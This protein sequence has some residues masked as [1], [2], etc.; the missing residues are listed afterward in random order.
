MFLLFQSPAAASPWDYTIGEEDTPTTVNTAATSA[1]VDTTG[2]EIRLP[3]SA[4]NTVAFW[5]DGSAAF[6]VLTP[7]E[8]KHYSYT[9]TQWVENS[10]L[11]VGPVSNPA[12]VAAP[13]PF[14]DV[15]VA[16]GDSLRHYS[17]TGSEMLN[18]P[19]LAVA[20]LAGVAALGAR[21]LDTAGLVGDQVHVYTGQNRNPALEPSVSFAN[22]VDLAL[23]QDSN[24]M[25]VLEP[26]RVRY[27]LSTGSSMVEAPALAIT[28][29]TAP[30]AVA[31]GDGFDVAVI[32]GNQVKHYSF[33]G[34][35][36]VYSSYLS[37]TS[38]L[39][40]P[41]S[42]ALRPGSY[43]RLVADGDQVKYY[44]WNG[45]S[46]DVPVTIPVPGLSS[47]G[48][49]APAAAVESVGFDPG[50]PVSKVRVRAAHDLPDGTMVTWSVTADGAD[51]VKRWRVR[52]TASGSVL[53]VSSDNG[54]TW[55]SIGTADG[56]APGADNAQ[57]WA[58]V[59]AGR[60][61]R[62]RAELS[63]TGSDT[64]RIR[65]SVPGG[66][67]VR[68]DV[69]RP[70]DPPKV[71]PG[72]PACHATTT[73]T[74]SWTFSD[75]DPGDRQ[76]AYRVQIVKPDLELVLDTGK[77]LSD[78]TSYTVPTSTAPDQAGPLWSAGEYEFKVRVKVWDS[79]DL[80][81]EWSDYADFCVTAFE[82]PR[83][84][85]IVSPPP[86]QASPDPDDPKTHIVI[87]PGMT[88]ADLPKVKAGA[89]VTVIIDSVGPLT[90][91]NPV[92]S[93]G[94]LQATTTGVSN[95]NSWGSKV[96]RF[97]VDFWTSASLEDCPT[98]TVVQMDW[99]GEAA[100]LDPT[101]RAPPYAAGVV[102]TEG[103]VLNDYFVILKGRDS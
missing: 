96:N 6:V 98:G 99:S 51:W 73:P 72:G 52:G 75:P 101:F 4:P 83:I 70:P 88:E 49:Y 44:R 41:T 32:D 39:S 91:A 35:S 14:P 69:A 36:M 16:E 22:P 7:T 55:T 27:F 62:W 30:K 1:V 53:E 82:R 3:R 18:N 80:E 85:E 63:R 8:V 9:G 94:T 95:L 78:S 81:S 57:L 102:R 93:Y 86:G 26:N 97:T 24:N 64:P 92:F 74:L 103:T 47:V 67:A 25:V 54:V 34:S 5:P 77:V 79:V 76:T 100:T 66:V 56:A 29:L 71:D 11:R 2:R 90:A 10:I 37:V 43:D 58:D 46:F 13:A 20:G 21:N 42:V 28:G 23:F 48:S 12:A 15:V 19:S 68:L 87:L 84:A 45:S 40:A 31:A 50:V 38:G 65:A 61:V 89:K 33:N 17:F 60:S 59:P